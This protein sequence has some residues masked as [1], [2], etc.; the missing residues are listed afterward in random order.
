MAC[1]ECVGKQDESNS[2]T[3]TVI[4][5]TALAS[6]TVGMKHYNKQSAPTPT[7]SQQQQ[8]QQ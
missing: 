1:I 8:Q 6:P 2:V 4:V 5:E 3:S 7:P